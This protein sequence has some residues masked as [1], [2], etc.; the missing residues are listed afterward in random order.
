M[1]AINRVSCQRYRFADAVGVC[2]GDQRRSRV[3]DDNIATW[4]T[5]TFE[6]GANDSC[7]VRGVAARDGGERG[8][9]QAELFGGDFIGADIAIAHFGD[10]RRAGY[11][12]LVETVASVD[13]K[14][15]AKPEL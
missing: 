7:V 2:C 12:D 8:R 10:L 9:F 11:G 13:H 15:A 14:R 4:G 3:E 5:F 1:S 6:H